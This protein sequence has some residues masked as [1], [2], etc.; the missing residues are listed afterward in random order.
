MDLPAH[1]DD[2][3]DQ[4]HPTVALLFAFAII[5]PA[6][7]LVLVAPLALLALALVTL[8]CFGLGGDRRVL[9]GRLEDLEHL[10]DFAPDFFR[11][12]EGDRPVGPQGSALKLGLVTWR[13]NGRRRFDIS[14]IDRTFP[15][16]PDDLRCVPRAR[17][18]QADLLGRLGTFRLCS[19]NAHLA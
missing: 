9:V 17:E 4:R 5:R 12:G 14:E 15:D 16:R 13:K 3:E 6:V 1:Q 10:L 11:F 19:P 18:P 2:L 8:A 7:L